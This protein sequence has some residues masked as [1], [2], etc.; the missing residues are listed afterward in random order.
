MIFMES[1]MMH[2]SEVR[3]ANA[4]SHCS[5]VCNVER[6]HVCFNLPHKFLAVTLTE[7]FDLN[8]VFFFQIH[9]FPS[10]TGKFPVNKTTA[11]V[12]TCTSVCVDE[13]DCATG[14]PGVG[15]TGVW[16]MDQDTMC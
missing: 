13:L 8:F 12:S 11:A 15:E 2:G 6:I 9:F 14:G 4:E 7:S 10:E 1:V 16:H 5:A 3:T